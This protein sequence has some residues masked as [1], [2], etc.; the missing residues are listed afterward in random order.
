MN[1]DMSADQNPRN[2]NLYIIGDNNK[3]NL[4]S[5]EVQGMFTI[6]TELWHKKLNK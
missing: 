2:L 3:V 5:D 4:Q 1:T 6:F